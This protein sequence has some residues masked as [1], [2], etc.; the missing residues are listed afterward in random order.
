MITTISQKDYLTLQGVLTLADRHTRTLD[1]LIQ[2]V[3]DI[4]GEEDEYN[5]WAREA[6]SERYS[7]DDLL[8]KLKIT[9]EKDTDT[10]D[11]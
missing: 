8:R 6:T 7:A 5:D 4:I 2:I 3:S 11:V 10:N 9:I 1:D